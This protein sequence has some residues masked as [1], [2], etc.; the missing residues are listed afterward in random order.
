MNFNIGPVPASTFVYAAVFA[1]VSIAFMFVGKLVANAVTPYND[2][3]QI[4]EKQNLAVALRTI[5]IFSGLVIGMAGALGG[6]SAGFG[7]D[8]TEFALDGFI[9]I[10]LLMSAKLIL[11]LFTFRSLQPAKQV[12]EG[13]TA[14][15]MV[16]CAAYIAT[17]LIINGAFSDAGLSP[18]AAAGALH[19]LAAAVLY[20]LIGQVALGLSFMVLEAIT[21]WNAST[22]LGKGNTAAGLAV[23]AKLVATGMILQAAVS[24]PMTGW[25]DDLM[26]FGLFFVFG[27]AMLSLANWLADL[28]FLPGQKVS[29]A[30]T[31]TQN[32]A[33]VAK[34]AGVQLSVA[35]VIS[36]IL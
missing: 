36:T 29:E 34:V 20:A 10:A 4:R 19:P 1:L 33:A 14:V 25:A 15:G 26:A 7:A 23:A 18:E 11:H 13:N 16:E 6:E 35:F 5:G 3:H 12:K 8:L 28:L 21:P 17:G 2:D 22:E 27:M 24:G 32:L 9:V 31:K 30:V